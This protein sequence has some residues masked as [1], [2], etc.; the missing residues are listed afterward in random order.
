MCSLM[1][2]PTIPD[3]SRRLNEITLSPATHR[4]L[5]Q[6]LGQISFIFSD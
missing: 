5:G 3:R 6:A 1:I 2:L 4:P